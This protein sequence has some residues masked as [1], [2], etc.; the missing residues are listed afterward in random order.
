MY[1]VHSVSF[2]YLGDNHPRASWVVL[3]S[4]PQY[5]HTKPGASRAQSANLKPYNDRVVK[6]PK[7]NAFRR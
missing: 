4:C 1:P 3:P 7:Q 2:H 5:Q 6:G